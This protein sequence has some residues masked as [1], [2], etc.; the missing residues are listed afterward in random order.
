MRQSKK[1]KMR[2]MEWSKW[3]NE[4]ETK[5]QQRE[6]LEDRGAKEGRRWG[7][8][9]VVVVVWGGG[10]AWQQD[11]PWACQS[12]TKDQDLCDT[13]VLNLQRHSACLCLYLGS[14]VSHSFLSH[15]SVFLE[16]FSCFWSVI[17]ALF[18]SCFRLKLRHG[19]SALF[20]IICSG[21]WHRA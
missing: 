18:L 20:D 19:I 13:S 1:R 3:R 8:P 2:G 10:S 14:C 5:W 15:F 4:A 7:G 9:T 11:V 21:R 6:K 17:P 16:A 12:L